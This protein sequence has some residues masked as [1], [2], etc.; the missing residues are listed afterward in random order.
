MA[1]KQ[2]KTLTLNDFIAKA[3]QKKQDEFR[4][5]KVYIKSLDGEITIEKIGLNSI[6]NAIDSIQKDESM[7]NIIDVYKELIYSSCKMLHNKEL[8]N[9]LEVTDPLDTVTELFE[10]G[11]IMEIGEEILSLHGFGD[12]Q[13]T[14]K[15]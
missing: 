9:S 5:K 11:E 1:K 4:I 7:A 15:N 6:T 13:A 2:A 10:L 8:H 12:L 3:Q 14:V